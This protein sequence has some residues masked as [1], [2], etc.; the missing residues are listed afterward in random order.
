MSS[1]LKA[2]KK[3][4]NEAPEQS[5]VQFWSQKKYSQKTIHMRAKGGLRLIKQHIIIILFVM[6]LAVGGGLILSR[7]PPEKVLAPIARTE[8]KPTKHIRSPEKRALPQNV[9]QIEPPAKKDIKKSEPNTKPRNI[10]PAPVRKPLQE[11][12]ALIEKTKTK[13]EE[14]IR[15]PEKSAVLQ[16]LSQIE[17]QEKKGVEKAEQNKEIERFSSLPVKQTNDSGLELQAIAWSSDPKNR[18][19]V[20]NGRILREGESIERVQVTHIGKDNVIFKDGRNEWR[21][22]FRIK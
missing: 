13:P 17:P 21:Q 11:I 22:V 4:E 12:P 5:K 20:I 6:I 19:A 3:L 18:I 1:I 14:R 8:I 15:S 16:D 7:K 10:P 9:A 2:L